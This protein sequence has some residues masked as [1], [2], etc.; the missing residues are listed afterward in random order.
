MN[1]KIAVILAC[2]LLGTSSCTKNSK[3]QDPFAI[4]FQ[5]IGNLTNSTKIQELDS[6][7]AKDSIVKHIAG[8]EFISTGHEIEIYEKGGK[9]L[10]ALEATEEFD[11]TAT[12][13]SVRIVDPRYKTADG[14]SI[15]STFEHIKNNHAISKI[16][17]TLSTALVFIDS[18]GIYLTIDKKVLPDNLR[19][20]SDITIK[21]SQ[22]PDH[23][24]V[25][26]LWI[27]WD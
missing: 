17:N 7:F 3:S 22:I 19:N 5:R 8:D 12:I 4:S 13:A 11:S 20:N 26:N 15:Q 24:T 25:K 10:L 27:G 16:S 23:A 9:Q 14:L 18:L 21:A 6:I 1:S 2:I